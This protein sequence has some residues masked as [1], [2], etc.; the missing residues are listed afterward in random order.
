MIGRPDAPRRSRRCK[1][2][3]KS[4]ADRLARERSRT[5]FGTSRRAFRGTEITAGHRRRASRWF[6][7]R[8]PNRD[9]SA[10]GGCRRS[11]CRGAALSWTAAASMSII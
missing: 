2:E 7:D 8:R 1:S 11:S 4:I 5:K 6:K 10:P 3:I 9:A